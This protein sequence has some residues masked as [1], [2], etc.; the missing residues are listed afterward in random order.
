MARAANY[1]MPAFQVFKISATCPHCQQEFVYFRLLKE[2][3]RSQSFCSSE[4]KIAAHKL[5]N[6]RR[7][8]I[9]LQDVPEAWQE[10]LEAKARLMERDHGILYYKTEGITPSDRKEM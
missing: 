4:C 5:R 6:H 3:G 10:R 7:E 9:D 1:L 2:F 8:V